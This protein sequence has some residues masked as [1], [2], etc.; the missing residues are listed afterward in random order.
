M[1]IQIWIILSYFQYIILM[2]NTNVK[3]L[4]N[5]IKKSIRKIEGKK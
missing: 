2:I 1:I 3:L 5:K 4:M